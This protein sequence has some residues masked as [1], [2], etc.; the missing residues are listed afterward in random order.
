[1]EI[2]N[3]SRVTPG[4]RDYISSIVSG[5]ETQK[6][7]HVEVKDAGLLSNMDLLP[8]KDILQQNIYAPCVFTD[9][10]W[11]RQRLAVPELMDIFDFEV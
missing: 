2:Q 11:C 5:K 7:S 1:M 3:K 9:S 4:I 6:L 10:K 8:R